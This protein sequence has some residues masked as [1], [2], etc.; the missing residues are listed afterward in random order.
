MNKPLIKIEDVSKT[1]RLGKIDVVA[2]Q[3]INLKINR[4]DFVSIVG[5]SG[6]GKSTLLHLIS[7]LDKPT[8]GRIEINGTDIST[9]TD[10]G[11]T[12]FRKVNIGFVFQFFN[13]IPTFSL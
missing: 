12:L 10:D 11:R 13:L 1:Y 5:P 2:L 6:A 8:G 4:K 7:G 9:L 3:D